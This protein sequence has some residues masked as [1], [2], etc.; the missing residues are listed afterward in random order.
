[1]HVW[2]DSTLC[3]PVD[4]SPPGCFAH[5]FFRQEYWSGWASLI[6]Q[7]VKNPPAM[8]ETWFDSWVGKICWIRDRL[9]TPLFLGFPCSSAGKES[10]CNTGVLGSTSVGNIPWRREQLPSSVFWP[11]EFHGLYSPWG[12]RESDMT[13]QLLLWLEW[14]AFSFSSQS[15]QPRKAPLNS[16]HSVKEANLRRI[17]VIWF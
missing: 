6:A 4:C 16:Y 1:M 11:G 8:Q 5:G 10:T 13:E 3:N 17:Y 12:H 15:S 9:P 2:L 7:L 14:V